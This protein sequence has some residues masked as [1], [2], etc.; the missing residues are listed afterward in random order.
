MTANEKLIGL[1]HEGRSAEGTRDDL[2]AAVRAADSYP[3]LWE[4]LHA[5]GKTYRSP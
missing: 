4:V 3:N 1:A 5:T 2:L